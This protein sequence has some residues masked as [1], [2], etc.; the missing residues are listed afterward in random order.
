M[1]RSLY[2]CALHLHPPAFRKRFGDEMLAIFDQAHG[3][4]SALKLIFDALFSLSR[5]W[6]LR[7]EFWHPASL[8]VL[9]KPTWTV[10]GIEAVR[11]V[12]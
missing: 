7:P 11:G 8:H 12:V 1:L 10:S 2:R 3:T 5:Q 9:Q 4:A 6:T